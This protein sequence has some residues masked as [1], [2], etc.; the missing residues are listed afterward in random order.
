MN[1]IN[2]DGSGSTLTQTGANGF[3]V[4]NFDNPGNDGVHAVNVTDNA[5][6]TT[7]TAF[8]AIRDTGTLT[9]NTGGQ[10]ITGERLFIEGTLNYELDSSSE[11]IQV[12]SSALVGDGDLVVDTAASFTP[13]AGDTF[14]LLEADVQGH[15]RL[16]IVV[17]R[18]RYVQRRAGRLRDTFVLLEADGGVSGVFDNVTFS[19]V[20]DDLQYEIVY[21]ANMV[22]LVV[23]EDFILGDVNLDGD[24]NFLD[25]ASFIT[26]LQN[27]PFL[28]EADINRDET[29]DFLDIAPFIELLLL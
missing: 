16:A 28:D 14:V 7:G 26:V 29:V 8:A 1:E 6:L 23:S 11:R 5:V 21:S 27:G 19:G 22:E 18:K 3:I 15:R 24:V 4:G 2:L 17:Q 12:G 13:T 25:I 20:P 10:L 9:I